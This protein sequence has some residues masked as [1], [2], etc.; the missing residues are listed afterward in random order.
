MKDIPTRTGDVLILSTAGAGDTH[1]IGVVSRDGQQDLRD[2]VALKVVSG[3]PAAEIEARLMVSS[4]HRIFL[5][6]QSTG[7]WDEIS[8]RPPPT[9]R[10]YPRR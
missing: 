3:R 10:T 9:S 1:A 8:N 7:E 4:S 6:N 2:R 5:K